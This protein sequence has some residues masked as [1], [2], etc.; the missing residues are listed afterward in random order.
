MGALEAING[1]K[2]VIILNLFKLKKEN[3]SLLFLFVCLFLFVVGFL[4]Y[5]FSF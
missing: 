4:F 3:K 1:K 2:N 5:F